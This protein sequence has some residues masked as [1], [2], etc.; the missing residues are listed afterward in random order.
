MR[1]QALAHDG[2]W[3]VITG[4]DVRKLSDPF[5]AA[6][7]TPVQQ[8]AL[9]VERVRYVGEPVALV[10]AESR[11]LAE[12]AAEL[13]EIEYAPL[14]G[15]R[16]IRKR[17][18]RAR[19]R[20]CIRKP[21]PTKSRCANFLWRHRRGIRPRRPPHRHD[22]AGFR[23]CRSLRS[24]ATSCVA[25]HNP[26]EGSYD[27][28]ANF[29]GPFSMHPVMAR[30]LRVAG[31]ETAPAHP[32]RFRRQFR[33][34]AFG[35]SLRRAHGAG[36][37]HHRP[38]G[39]MGRGPHRASGRREFRPEPGDAN[40]SRGDQRRPHSRPCGST[41]SKITARFCA[42]RCRVRSTACRAR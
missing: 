10:V 1:R 34:Q 24:N 39:E 26:A 19:R 31:T 7:K 20:C 6:V 11:Y 12:D 3:A 28:L 33:H 2:V 4:E 42:R 30:A 16:S 18:A 17:H 21:R 40:R 35:V 14:R 36:G 8:W 27:V 13:V 5:L 32:A 25:Q 9:A 38:A 23:A 37:A 29:Q 22:D 41:S 15:R